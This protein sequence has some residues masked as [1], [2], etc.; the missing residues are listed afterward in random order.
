MKQKK[1]LVPHVLVA[2]FIG[3]IGIMVYVYVEAK[4]LNPVMLDEH[5]HVRGEKR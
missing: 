1:T 2:I 5:G 3:F 4:R